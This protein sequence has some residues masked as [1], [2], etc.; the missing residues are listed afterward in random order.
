MWEEE[1][2]KILNCSESSCEGWVYIHL[3]LYS[4]GFSGWR[5]RGS[6]SGKGGTAIP[7]FWIKLWSLKDLDPPLEK[8]IALGG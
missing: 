1:G 4:T 8:I 6:V 5:G 2:E 3:F 7:G